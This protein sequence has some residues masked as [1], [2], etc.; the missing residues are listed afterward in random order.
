MFFKEKKYW[1]K[2]LLGLFDGGLLEDK[3]LRISKLLWVV[4]E[5]PI[6]SWR[7]V[8]MWVVEV[9]R[10]RVAI[11]AYY[12]IIIIIWLSLSVETELLDTF[13]ISQ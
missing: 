4:G 11:V 3:V 5:E 10:D 1:H 9:C 2:F 8:E 7:D 13:G 6:E 12:W